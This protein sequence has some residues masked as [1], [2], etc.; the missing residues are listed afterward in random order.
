MAEDHKKNES[1]SKSESKGELTKCLYTLWYV[2]P[3]ATRGIEFCCDWCNK[4]ARASGEALN[5]GNPWWYQ[6]WLPE[7]PYPSNFVCNQCKE[8][9]R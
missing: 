6:R 3:M 1:E 4:P 9:V 5:L 8:D 2:E 7:D